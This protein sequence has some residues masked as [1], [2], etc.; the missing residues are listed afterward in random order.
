MKGKGYKTE[1]NLGLLYKSE[2]DPQIEK[3]IASLEKACADFEKKYKGKDF[4]SNA[5]RLLPALQAYV[6]VND[7]TRAKPWW[8]FALRFEKN[9]ADTVATAKS[10]QMQERMTQAFNKLTFFPL[11]LGV[12]APKQQKQFLKDPSLGSFKYM[13]ERI[14]LQSKYNLSEKEEQLAGLLSQTSYTLWTEG[15]RKALFEHTIS[16]KGEDLPIS[17]ARE[18]LAEL[19]RAERHELHQKLNAVY[20]QNAIFAESELNAIVNYKKIMDERRGHEKP[21]SERLLGDEVDEKTLL[22]LVSIVTKYFTISKKFFVLH[23]RLLG[24]KVLTR[25]DLR[26][27]FGKIDKTFTFDETLQFVQEAFA[28]VDKRYADYVQ[29]FVTNGHIDVYSKKG[30]AGGA[31]CWGQGKLPIYVLLNHAD[32]LNSVET[33]AHEMG[34]AIHGQ[35]SCSLPSQYRGHSTA[36]AEV[37][38]TFFEQLVA[39]KLITMLDEKEQMI[40]LHSRLIKS[41]T[42]VFTQVMGFNYELELHT[43]IRERGQLTHREIAELLKKQYDTFTGKAVKSTIEDGYSFVAWSH[44]RYFFYTYSYAY[45]LLVSRALY[46]KWKADPS[47]AKKIEQFL[48]AGRSMSPTDIFKSIGITT[49]QAFF[50]AGLKGIEADIKKLEKLAKKYKKI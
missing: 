32:N 38:S 2:K 41:V 40:L 44:T 13:L 43:L 42:T 5:K 24:Q 37:A 12:I 31:F 4:T 11:V 3:D 29:S 34:H 7:E 21:Y 6:N 15:Q 50:E 39:D 28:Q 46:E 47:Y 27:P 49:D 10:T 19:P 45:G 23:A 16:L 8:Y 48:S 22:D 30:K 26:V 33:L 14:F 36:T 9:S 17:K 1:W 18:I 35:L 20:M 25:A